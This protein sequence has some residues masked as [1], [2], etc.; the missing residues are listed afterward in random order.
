MF[1]RFAHRS[2]DDRGPAVSG[3][4]TKPAEGTAA[5][6]TAKRP[7]QTWID[8]ARWVAIVLVVVGHAVGLLR[9][10]SGLAVIVSNYVYIFHIPVFVMLAGWGAR[11]AEA[12]GRGLTKI[13]WQLLVPYILFQLIAFG[14]NYLFEDDTPS[15]S[16][17]SQTFGLWFLVALAAWRLI[18]P[19]FRGLSYAVPLAVLLALAAGLSPNID[20]FLSLSRVLYFLPMFLLGPWL[21]DRISAWRE[22]VRFRIGGVA[23]LAAGAV[24]TVLLGRDFNRQPFL[25][26]TGYDAMNMSALEGTGWRLLALA[27][28]TLMAAAF[29]LALPGRPNAPSRW[30]SSVATAG[31]HTMYPYLLHLPLLTVAGSTG[32]VAAGQ[33]TVRTVAFIA[34]SVV[35][36]ILASWKPVRLV[37]SP[38][39]EPRSL[40]PPAH[41]RKVSSAP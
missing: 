3:S 36:C 25:G 4:I 12:D 2:Q 10:S 38:V 32:L 31:R 35:F 1:P 19:W 6:P 5:G 39:V 27:A 8:Q 9:G 33:P 13:F 14:F 21:V 11:R 28:G 34:A 23:V 16:F 24:L 29:M 30:G 15:W 17:T 26:N 40:F 7:R 41:D 22:D 18:A 20:G 37:T